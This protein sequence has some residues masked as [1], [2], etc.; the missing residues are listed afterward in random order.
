MKRLLVLTIFLVG[1]CSFAPK[2]ERPPL[3]V[4][5]AYKE[6]GP[7]LKASPSSVE[8]DRGPWWLM[9]NDADL[10]QLE[11]AIQ[12]GNFSLKAALA[13]VDEA[14]AI[15]AEERS[16]L[17]PEILGVFNANRQQLS[18]DTANVP[19]H[20]LF[21]DF[22]LSTNVTYELD[23]WGRVRNA[24]ASAGSLARASAADMM[25]IELSLRA[26]LASDYFTLRGYDAAQR[27]LD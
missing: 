21:N 2:Y 26:E 18:K 15:V 4:P 1:G 25:A 13:R 7:W 8:L 14:R 9:F 19:R 20:K 3:I 22:L 6:S 11:S 24:V 5:P 16:A 17:Y 23:V 27:I 12:F 10:N